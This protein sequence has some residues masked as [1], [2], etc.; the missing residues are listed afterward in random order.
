MAKQIY[1][2]RGTVTIEVFKRVKAKDEY[3]AMELAHKHFSGLGEY[4]GNGGWDKIIGVEG[5]SESV[6]KC[7]DYVHWQEAYETDDGRYDRDTDSGIICKC[8]LCGEEF[9]YDCEEDWKYNDGDDQWEH[10]ES[11]HEEKYNECQ[12]WLTRD[13]LDEYFIKAEE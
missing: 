13:M 2:V 5:E 4:G 3:E 8:K 10:L 12:E 11:E 7:G 1:E 6:Q 9:Y